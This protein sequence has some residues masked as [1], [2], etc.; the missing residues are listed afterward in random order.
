MKYLETRYYDD[1]KVYAKL[2]D[3][4]PDGQ[5]DSNKYDRY[6]ETIGEGGCYDSI[7][8]YIDDILLIDLDDIMPMII[9]FEAGECI[10]ITDCL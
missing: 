2:H 1:G 6:I 3:D 7:A 10:D 4:E 9:E 5:Y 8:A